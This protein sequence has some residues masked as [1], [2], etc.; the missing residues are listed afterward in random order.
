MS[1]LGWK[2]GETERLYSTLP[3]HVQ[4]IGLFM[5]LLVVEMFKLKSVQVVILQA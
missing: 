5:S 2:R 3:D 4:R 1:A